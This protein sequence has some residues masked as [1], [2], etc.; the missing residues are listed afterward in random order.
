MNNLRN[1]VQLIGHLGKDVEYRVLDN[2]N[3]LARV[4]IATKEVYHNQ[5]GEKIVDVQWHQL[6]GWGK[7]AEMM[8]ILCKK[9]KEVAVQGKLTHRS[10][11]DQDGNTRYLSEII[12][13][14]FMLLN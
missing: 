7:L 4:S 1:K 8:Q 6:V 10:Y 5:K 11:E 13:N 9:G 2:G 3:A 12:V 14:E